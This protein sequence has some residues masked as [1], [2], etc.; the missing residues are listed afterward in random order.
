NKRTGKPIDK[1]NIVKGVKQDDGTYVIVD[2]DEI[3]AAYPKTVQTIVIESFVKAGEI[4]FVYHE[5]PYVLEPVARADKVYALLREAMIEHG[6]GGIGRLV[7]HTKE[8]LAALMPTGP[9]LALDTLR[10]ATELRSLDALKLPPAGRHAVNLKESE[11]KMA[12][13]LI[14]GMTEAW[15]P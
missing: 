13:E 5:K 7:M 8:H 11:L 9:A 12:G 1:E 4:P 15:N 6:V 14:D 10:W 2:E 3:R